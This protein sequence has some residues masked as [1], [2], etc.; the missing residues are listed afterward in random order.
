MLTANQKNLLEFI[1]ATVDADGIP[2]TYEQMKVAVGLESKSGINRMIK[3]L[4]ER[5]FI[6][7]IPARA[8]AIEVIRRPGHATHSTAW[9]LDVLEKIEQQLDY[10]QSDA[11]HRIA[12]ETITVLRNSH[13]DSVALAIEGAAAGIGEDIANVV[14]GVQ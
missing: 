4:E 5:G 2:P 1:I 11:A 14:G 10:G 12:L 9:F 3:A 13:R 7:R 6:R 8:R